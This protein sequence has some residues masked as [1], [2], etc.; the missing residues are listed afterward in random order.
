MRKAFIHVLEASIAVIILISSVLYISPKIQ[1]QDKDES[2][3]IYYFMFQAE[4]DQNFTSLVNTNNITG[5]YNYLYS[6]IKTYTSIQNYYL[7]LKEHCYYEYTQNKTLNINPENTTKIIAQ[8]YINE[9]K[10]LSFIQIYPSSDKK[11]TGKYTNLSISVNTNISL[12]INSTQKP[13]KLELIKYY[14]YGNTLNNEIHVFEHPL[15]SESCLKT[16][17]IKYTY[18]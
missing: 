11:E 17:K 1:T 2:Y 5:I 10:D 3:R 12:T 7:D 14:G 15:K 18:S 4:N 13:Y 6:E 8:T 16:L 9:T